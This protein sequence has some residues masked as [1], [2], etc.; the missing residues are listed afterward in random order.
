LQEY[1]NQIKADLH[2]HTYYSDGILSPQELVQ[3]A[4]DSGL[5]YLSVT[6][7]DNVDGLP[8]AIDKGKEIG[9]EVIPGVE[10]SSQLKDLEVHVLGYFMD[11]NYQE[12]LDHLKSFRYE[13]LKRAERIVKKL[14]SMDVD[15]EM[16]D[17]L[18]KVKGNA[19]IGRPHIAFAMIEKKI[20][21]NYYEAFAKYIGDNKPAYERKPNIST[22][23]AIT[24]IS[25]AGGISIVAHPGKTLR[26]NILIEIME[27]GI[28]G[29]EVIH[30]SHNSEDVRYFRDFASQY[31]MLESGGSDFHGGRFNDDTLMGSFWITEQKVREMKHRLFFK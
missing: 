25:K 21:S 27:L 18:S 8:E 19:S 6:D 1:A 26:D 10:L 16:S 3:K 12:L 24:L 14:N 13:R 29:F 9:I 11:C 2:A 17:V 15:I 20:V 30:P 4:K 22:K 23:D 7:H 28:D 31:F 5:K